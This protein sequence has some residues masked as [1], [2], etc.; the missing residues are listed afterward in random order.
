MSTAEDLAVLRRA[1]AKRTLAAVGAADERLEAAYG[2]VRR[3]DF[4]DAG[5][6]PI[7]RLGRGYMTTPSADPLYLY[8]DVL[9]GIA[10]ERQ[11]NNGQPSYHAGHI[12]AAGPK[13]GE[14]VVHVGAGTG[15]YSAILAHMVGSGGAVTAMEFDPELA[16]RARANLAP[17]PWVEVTCGNGA[18]LPFRPADVIYVN[19]GT[20]GPAANWLDGL[21]EGGRLILPLTAP[22]A[23][24]GMAGAGMAGIPQGWAGAVFKIERRG[25]EFLAQAL[26]WVGIIPG[27]GLREPAAEAALTEAFASQRWRDVRRLHRRGDL[28]AEDCWVRTAQWSLAFR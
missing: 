4:L 6:W 16:A 26:G 1:Y 27:E 20:T 10:P 24:A 5:P 21:R 7:M 13:A 14:H 3:E 17:W 15:Y 19:V 11:L 28:A 23:G 18:E 22:M 8:D 9:V 2:E 12:A 25:A